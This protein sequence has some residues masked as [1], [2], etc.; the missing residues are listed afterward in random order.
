MCH[1]AWQ[2]TQGPMSSRLVFTVTVEDSTILLSAP[3]NAGTCGI[4]D[5][6]TPAVL[7]HPRS[8][9]PDLVLGSTHRKGGVGENSKSLGPRQEQQV[10]RTTEPSLQ[11]P[12]PAFQ[13]VGEGVQR[14]V[15]VLPSVWVTVDQCVHGGQGQ[16]WVLILTFKK[17]NL[18]LLSTLN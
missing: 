15:H 14:C 11:S 8:S 17:K 2:D 9:R 13:S 6:W 3:P 5:V 1:P 7:E 10:F 4:L 16:P 12:K 18:W